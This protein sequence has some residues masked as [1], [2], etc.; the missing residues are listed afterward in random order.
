MKRIFSL[1]TII[2]FSLSAFVPPPSPSAGRK[3]PTF[4]QSI[5]Q[6]V[7]RQAMQTPTFVNLPAHVK[8]IIFYTAIKSGPVLNIPAQAKA[9]LTIAAVN[10]SFRHAINDPVNTLALLQSLP[11]NAAALYLADKLDK[12]PGI[13]SKKVQAWLKNSCINL[14]GYVLWNAVTADFTQKSTKHTIEALKNRDVHLNWQ[15]GN[16]WTML[17]RASTQGNIEIV[18]L[19]LAAGARVS[20]PPS[21]L[22]PEALFWA[23][24]NGK[25][26]IVELLLAAGANINARDKDGY[27]ALDIA[28]VEAVPHVEIGEWRRTIIKI[29][30][31]AGADLTAQNDRGQ[32]VHDIAKKVGNREIIQLIEDAKKA[33]K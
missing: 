9:F 11:T 6:E 15:D 7:K 14:E 8:Q 21:A 26:Q 5:Q 3:L 12:T 1:T 19:L 20:G 33:Q 23:A 22:R 16:Q 25:A 28:V 29:L 13:E 31:A 24:Y 32:N 18:K 2:T 10:R 17:T 27:T 4:E 30:L